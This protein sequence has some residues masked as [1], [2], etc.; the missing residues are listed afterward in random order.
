MSCSRPSYRLSREPSFQQLVAQH[1]RLDGASAS[2]LL[3][4]RR[5]LSGEAILCLP[6]L[7]HESPTVPYY[8][9]IPIRYGFSS[10][11]ADNLCRQAASLGVTTDNLWLFFNLQ[12]RRISNS[13]GFDGTQEAETTHLVAPHAQVQLM[14][15]RK[16]D[17]N[18][19]ACRLTD[20]EDRAV[21]YAQ[22]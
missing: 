16:T 12:R 10:E 17:I 9:P 4:S 1:Y 13:G 6:H 3:L 21:T 5:C 14:R 11:L 7:L 8:N 22:L 2:S 19:I 15:E 18:A 20:M